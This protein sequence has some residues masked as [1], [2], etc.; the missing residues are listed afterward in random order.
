MPAPPAPAVDFSFP[1]PTPSLRVLSI[2]SH[3]VSGHVGNKVAAFSL[4]LL[5]LDVD[6]LNT[7]QLSN[8]TG[9]VHGARGPKLSSA[10]FHALL[11]GMRANNL[12]A[13]ISHVLTG[14]AATA[15]ALGCI[16]RTMRM[17]ADARP[18]A[19]PKVQ[20][21]C[22]PVLGDD[23]RLYVPEALMPVYRT[24]VLPLAQVCCPNAF[25]LSLL[26]EVALPACDADVVAGCRIMHERF[27]VPTVVVT[28]V[29]FE[30]SNV[31]SMFVSDACGDFFALDADKLDARFSGSGDLTSA[32]ILAWRERLPGRENLREAYRNVMS[33]VTGVLKRTMS[34]DRRDASKFCALPELALVQSARDIIEPP[35][36]LVR[37]REVDVSKFT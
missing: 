5:G 14:F 27:G 20:Y 36:G 32:L 21:V 37:V 10:D 17:L 24:T 8:H 15:E 2:Q 31:V 11:D 26:A 30:A 13:Q 22:D 3:V 29:S 19:A 16:E 35:V 1:L 12:L 18:P 28:G 25:E 7:C 34:L 6:V 4:Q 9:Y 23:G 33:S